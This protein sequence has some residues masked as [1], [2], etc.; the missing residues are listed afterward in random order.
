MPGAQ[1]RSDQ[2]AE[3]NAG[4]REAPVPPDIL[5]AA[6]RPERDSLGD[7]R[8]RLE[9]LPA[10]HPSSPFNDDL[11]R[12]A[13]VA[14]LKD[15]EL[16]LQ[17]GERGAPAAEAANSPA[18]AASAGTTAP[19]DDLVPVQAASA[20][21]AN[22][23]QAATGAD[24]T[25]PG[26]A[27]SPAVAA[28]STPTENLSAAEDA[29]PA[30]D[31]LRAGAQDSQEAGNPALAEDTAPAESPPLAAPVE[32]YGPADG[33]FVAAA[34][35]PARPN[36]SG[37]LA[38]GISTA[39][40]TAN[41]YASP[42]P[43]PP[44]DGAATDG[45]RVQADPAC[46]AQAGPPPSGPP[47][48]DAPR[49]GPTPAQPGSPRSGPPRSDAEGP[50]PAQPGSSRSGPAR[51]DASRSGPS[52]AG[53]PRPDPAR[54]DEARLDAAR[55]GPPR[56][57]PPRSDP[58][59]FD[60]ARPDAARP[61]PPRTGPPRS[62]AARFD[63]ARPDAARSGPPRSDVTRSDA[64]RS[65]P[66]RSDPAR[67]GP[68]RSDA[69][70]PDATRPDTG[71]PGP[72]RSDRSDRTYADP[73]YGSTNGSRTDDRTS[74][75]WT[76]N[77]S[78]SP[79][80]NRAPGTRGGAADP[81]RGADR[82]GPPGRGP[83]ERSGP[84]GRNASARGD[85][86]GAPG[87]RPVAT[88]RPEPPSQTPP[89][90]QEGSWEANGRHLD[91]AQNRIADEALSRCRKAEGRNVFGTYGHSGLTAA[92]RRIEA[93]LDRGQLVPDTE[94]QALKPP[95]RFKEKFADLIM[96]HPDKSAEELADEV[97]DGVRYTFLFDTAH[98]TEATL[99]V[100][101]RLKGQ[102]FELEARRNC[103][104]NAEYKGINTRWRDPAHD[105]AFEVLFHT[106]SS[107]D[108]RQR[109]Q[110]LYRKITDAATSPADRLRL[111]EMRADMSAKILV[112]PGST[113]IP[114]FYKEG[115]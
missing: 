57:G 108:V 100:H 101:S 12:K 94:T 39:D 41:G 114:D 79:Y 111:R 98:Y 35:D 48:P 59:R 92:M 14:R 27:A 76:S 56:T 58:A 68:P 81:R 96:R 32:G 110:A 113:T 74:N 71:R 51:H 52:R 17:G 11:T 105:L 40:W 50:S 22:S 115:Q 102:G 36:G 1:E 25:V 89:S 6:D 16:P 37:T 103:W 73:S 7:L 10:G 38:G 88:T 91:L 9:R 29:P 53:P 60:A 83:A 112:P 97:H 46:P 85:Q 33:A 78:A 80:E 4:T 3:P 23:A 84:A 75:D 2:L 44:E 72:A 86:A 28:N 67:S 18:A 19:A 65:G 69:T 107:W 109:A 8:R 49:S 20:A 30:K 61:G 54:F 42:Y 106:T 63:P 55:S 66:P 45:G 62:D 31:S 24:D 15:L 90:A 21:L 64:A 87:R 95:D 77:E 70:R 104:E 5:R 13:P 93:L 99:Q 43:D 47:R 34:P 26:Q 82:S